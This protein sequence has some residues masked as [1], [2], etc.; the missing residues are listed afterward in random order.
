[1]PARPERS[2]APARRTRGQQPPSPVKAAR[3]KPI[4]TPREAGHRSPE[5]PRTD[6]GRERSERGSREGATG[7]PEA[8]E[9]G[10]VGPR[11]Q[12]GATDAAAP[13]RREEGR[14]RVLKRTAVR[15]DK[16]PTEVGVRWQAPQTPRSPSARPAHFRSG[17]RQKS[18]L[19]AKPRADTAFGGAPAATGRST[20]P[21]RQKPETAGVSAS[22]R[23]DQRE[24]RV[25]AG[26]TREK[27]SCLHGGARS[28]KPRARRPS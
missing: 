2:P 1:M 4:K 12:A 18:P 22:T 21:Y 19:G 8:Y 11:A 13:E 28:P 25:D 24:H 14:S 10:E 20:P 5:A 23:C 7:P 15:K 6:A 9:R 17:S 3:R 27:G 16:N 26:T